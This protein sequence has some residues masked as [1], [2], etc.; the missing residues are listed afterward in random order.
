MGIVQLDMFVARFHAKVAVTSRKRLIE[1]CQTACRQWMFQGLFVISTRL[2]DTGT[3]RNPP[4]NCL[5][6]SLPSLGQ[7]NLVKMGGLLK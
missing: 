7:Q 5:T 6:S 3:P 1:L 4:F 2:N